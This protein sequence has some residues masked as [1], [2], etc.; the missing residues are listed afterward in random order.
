MRVEWVGVGE[1]VGDEWEWIS[2]EEGGAMDG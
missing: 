1:G 2:C